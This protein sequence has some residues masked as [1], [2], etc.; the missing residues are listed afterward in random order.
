MC[1]FYCTLRQRGKIHFT[2]HCK[3]KLEAKSFIYSCTSWF[4][5]VDKSMNESCMKTASNFWTCRPQVFLLKL[6]FPI[7]IFLHLWATTSIA[8]MGKCKKALFVGRQKLFFYSVRSNSI[9]NFCYSYILCFE[10]M[11]ACP[12]ELFT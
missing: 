12:F 9:L 10:A 8:F 1:N 6:F 2:C 4:P 7:F 5:L 3:R 11:F